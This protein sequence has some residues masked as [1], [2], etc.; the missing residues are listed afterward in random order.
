[1]QSRTSEAGVS[2]CTVETMSSDSDLVDITSVSVHREMYD[3]CAANSMSD[4][5]ADEYVYDD[6]DY[7]E[8]TTLAGGDNNN[9]SRQTTLTSVRTDVSN[10]PSSNGVVG[11][12]NAASVVPVG[13]KAM[14]PPPFGYPPRSQTEIMSRAVELIDSRGKHGHEDCGSN[15]NSLQHDNAECLKH[16]I[17]SVHHRGDGE[18]SVQTAAAAK[19]YG[20]IFTFF[21]ASPLFVYL[22]FHACRMRL[23]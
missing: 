3:R 2:Y 14:L 11:V 12:R 23:K 13:G 17:N 16:S 18:G 15:N 4:E 7:D 8:E 1:M 6:D 9:A 19:T 10:M 21:N 22:G 5:L 20:K